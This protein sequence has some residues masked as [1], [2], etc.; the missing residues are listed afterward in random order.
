MHQGRAS[1]CTRV[2]CQNGLHHKFQHPYNKWTKIKI[3]EKKLGWVG[4]GGGV[5]CGGM[6]GGYGCLNTY[7]K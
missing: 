1:E 5:G 4:G 2:E 3:K 7:R 6:S